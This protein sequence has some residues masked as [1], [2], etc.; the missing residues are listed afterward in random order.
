MRAVL[1]FFVSRWFLTGIGAA[2]LAA[3]VWFLGPLLA[4]LED[5]ILRAAIVAVI[6]LIWFGMNFWIMAR[7]NRADAELVAGAAGGAAASDASA[8]EVAEL[9]GKL[10]TALDLLKRARGTSGYLYEQ[11]DHVRI[12]IE[13]PAVG[14]IGRQE[15]APGIVDQQE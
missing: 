5:W 14:M 2:L 12:P 7:R 13:R 3:L 4:F 11:P 10:T 9:R 15:H 6:V 8:E 1:G